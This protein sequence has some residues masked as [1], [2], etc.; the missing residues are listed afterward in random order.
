VKKRFRIPVVHTTYRVA[1][2]KRKANCDGEAVQG[3]CNFA[4]RRLS[5]HDSDNPDTTRAVLWH[6]F[7]H[8]ALHELGRPDMR[9]D[10]ALVEGLALAVMRMRTEHPEI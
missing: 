3:F 8:A 10:E 4:D 1:L 6:E 7:F 2:T 5:V 9:D